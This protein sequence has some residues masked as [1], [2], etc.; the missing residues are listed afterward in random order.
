[1]IVRTGVVVGV[2]T[3]VVVGVKGVRTGVVVSVRTGV[4]VSVR[5][6]VVVG[7]RT[8][9]VVSV[10][11]VMTGYTDVWINTL[12]LP[13]ERISPSIRPCAHVTDVMPRTKLT[14]VLGHWRSWRQRTG[15]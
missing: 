14:M 1:V 10:K 2:R 7:V 12:S 15:L 5:T 11:G 8:G 13:N 9:V 3:G 6:G 4:V